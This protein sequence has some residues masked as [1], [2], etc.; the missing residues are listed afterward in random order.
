LNTLLFHGKHLVDIFTILQKSHLFLDE[1]ILGTFCHQNIFSF[2]Q[3]EQFDAI[4]I[5]A[6]FGCYRHDIQLRNQQD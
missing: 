5:L 6:T 4:Q 1:K 2:N 3:K